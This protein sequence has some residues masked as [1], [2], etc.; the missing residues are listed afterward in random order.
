M[1]TSTSTENELIDSTSESPNT[2]IPTETKTNESSNTEESTKTKIRET[3]TAKSSNK[4]ISKDT[5]VIETTSQSSNKEISK[6]TEVI[7]TTSQPSN[8]EISKDTEVIET[9]NTSLNNSEIETYVNT[10]TTEI[11]NTISSVTL[12]GFSNIDYSDTVDLCFYLIYFAA[13][14]GESFPKN[15]T[16]KVSFKYQ[17]TRILEELI[18]E[19]A[20]CIKMNSQITDLIKYNCSFSNNGK[21]IESL[22]C[23]LDFNFNE[24][25]IVITSVTPIAL[26]QSQNILEISEIN[27][28][29]KKLYILDNATLNLFNNNYKF[30]ITGTMNNETFNYDEINLTLSL[31]NLDGKSKSLNTSCSSIN[32]N[33]NN[34]IF[35][36]NST[37]AI[38]EKIKCGFSTFEEENLLVN[39]AEQ[40]VYSKSKFHFFSTKKTSAIS[41]G[42]IIGII[43]AIIIVIVSI[44]LTFYYLKKNEKSK[45]K[46]DS[47]LIYLD[48]N[49]TV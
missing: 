25:G 15:I 46:E 21:K 38:K 19:E 24:E 35:N 16:N 34:Y 2:E 3:T 45:V 7:E 40:T 32:N 49:I 18:E 14:N 17:N 37:T 42:I 11:I 9:T 27:M 31:D 4:E 23:S 41:A 44:I 22:S 20:E 10:Q 43:I 12:L 13:V 5:E 1:L 48:K 33:K 6:D 28:F 29:E 39:I 26:E 30:N 36:C 8:K 47:T